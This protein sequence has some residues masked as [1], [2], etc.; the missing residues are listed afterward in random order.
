MRF[1]SCGWV[2]GGEVQGAEVNT[3]SVG[4]KGERSEAPLQPLQQP[5]LIPRGL[6]GG[7]MWE[8]CAG[9]RWGLGLRESQHCKEGGLEA[10]LQRCP[11]FLGVGVMGE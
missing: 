8:R 7:Y 10:P 9:R 4:W 11:A 3:N 1:C 2:H 5:R 6:M